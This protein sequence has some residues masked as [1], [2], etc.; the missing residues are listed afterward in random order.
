[1]FRKETRDRTRGPEVAEASKQTS[2]YTTS[3]KN[4]HRSASY[5]ATVVKTYLNTLRCLRYVC[6]R[7]RRDNLGH[8][9]FPLGHGCFRSVQDNMVIEY[10]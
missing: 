7:Q 9:S 10:F 3:G 2:S 4:L 6:L 1:M 8:T 5:C